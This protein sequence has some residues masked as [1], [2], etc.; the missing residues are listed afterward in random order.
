VFGSAPLA[1]PDL[2]V[3]ALVGFLIVPVIAF[4]KWL[5]RR[6]GWRSLSAR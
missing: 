3:S 1:W 2:L 6:V 4:E 5:A